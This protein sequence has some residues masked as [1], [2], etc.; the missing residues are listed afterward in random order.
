M[1]KID[2]ND[3]SDLEKELCSE[4]ISVRSNAFAP[5]SGYKVGAALYADNGIIYTGC[6][7]ESP[8]YTLTSHAESVAIDSMVKSNCLNFSIIL[9]VL[10]GDK[11]D[12]FP[13]GLCLQKISE[14]SNPSNNKIII[15]NLDH[16][17]KI[18][19][20]MCSDLTTLLPFR[21]GLS[22]LQDNI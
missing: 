7:I 1:K 13:C 15:V 11:L 9:I 12:G 10:S 18:K 5:L 8:T 3:L 19:N 4:A 21:F 17:D 16:Q 20:I 2:Y 6:N 14:F 22:H